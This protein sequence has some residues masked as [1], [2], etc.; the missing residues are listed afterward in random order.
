MGMYPLWLYDLYLNPHQQNA[1]VV[2][3]SEGNVTLTHVSETPCLN[4][5]SSSGLNG[6]A[7]LEKTRI[8]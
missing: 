4:K 2:N 5:V 6:A 1:V 7:S 3:L 8:N